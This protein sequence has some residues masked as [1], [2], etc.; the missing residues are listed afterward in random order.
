VHPSDS[1]WKVFT[2]RIF[3]NLGDMEMDL[4]LGFKHRSHGTFCELCDFPLAARYA[5]L[6]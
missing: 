3:F 1:T 5:L 6:H 4:E 2:D